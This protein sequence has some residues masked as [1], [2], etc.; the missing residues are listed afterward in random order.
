[1][2]GSQAVFFFV[3]SDRYITGHI[4]LRSLS[5]TPMKY[6]G[7]EG[8]IILKKYFAKETCDIS[9]DEKILLQKWKL[10]G[11]FSG[12]VV[13]NTFFLNCGD[14]GKSYMIQEDR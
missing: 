12:Q 4:G 9:V 5:F 11:I 2:Q 1:M 10:W 13:P 7:V 6:L 8:C 3:F 14:R